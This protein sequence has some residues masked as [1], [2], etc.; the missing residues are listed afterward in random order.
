MDS[1]FNEYIAKIKVIGVGGA[2]NY[3]VN[4][5]VEE[6]I[7][8]VE[9]IVTNT[10]AQALM[11]SKVENRFSLGPDITKGLGA[12]AIP[13]VGRQAAESSI[14]DIRL[15]LSGADMVFMAAGM[16]GGTGTGAAPVIARVC[17]EMGCLTIGI[18]TRPFTFE[19]K[20]RNQNAV[21]GLQALRPHVDS[22]IVVSN[23]Q[24]MQMSGNV[25]VKD[26]FRQADNIL[27]HNVKTI[28]DLIVKPARI[29]L[30]F[31]DVRNI[32]A[33]KGTALI[34]MGKGNGINKVKEAALSAISSPLLESSIRGAKNAIVSIRGGDT[35]TILDTN[36]IVEIVRE[37]AGGSDINVIFGLDTDDTI[38]DTVEV[39]VI[40]TDFEG[41]DIHKINGQLNEKYGIDPKDSFRKIDLSDYMSPKTK[42]EPSIQSL[43]KN[44][45]EIEETNIDNDD[46]LPAFLRKRNK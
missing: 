31:A 44:F 10:D 1:Q 38:G 40:A 30:D 27:A 20:V 7:E 22:L 26:A 42:N 24:L 45:D 4:R 33:N 8:A 21:E 29:N 2:G 28:T 3:A 39:T 35:I 34:G 32:M 19:G 25:P 9:F 6:N 13:D 11:T 36:E 46:L 43:E 5:M 18:V 14:D 12:G 23:D 37:A 16:G 15:R 41:S 17:K